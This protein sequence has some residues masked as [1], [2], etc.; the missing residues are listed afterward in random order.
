MTYMYIYSPY[1]YMYTVVYDA[2]QY[3]TE[4]GYRKLQQVMCIEYYDELTAVG[5]GEE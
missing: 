4:T 5:V 1:I 2:M 3:N